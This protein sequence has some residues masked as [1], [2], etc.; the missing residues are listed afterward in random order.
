MFYN[1]QVIQ[2]MTSVKEPEPFN[3]FEPPNKPEWWDPNEEEYEE[4]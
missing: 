2:N 3:P 1:T 4:E